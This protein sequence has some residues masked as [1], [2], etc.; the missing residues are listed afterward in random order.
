MRGKSLW[1]ACLT[2]VAAQWGCAKSGPCSGGGSEVDTRPLPADWAAA[3]PIP[4]GAVACHSA[5]GS[6]DSEYDRRY[7]LGSSPQEGFETW[8]THLT[9]L[10]WAAGADTSS[11]RGH[12]QVFTREGATLK[13][14]VS[15][16]ENVQHK[17]WSTLTFQPG[18]K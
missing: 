8:R 3:A 2:I 15:R 13:V 16:A 5:D 18:P 9:G 17:G 1:I 6:T 7:E 11:E 12:E 10:G 14:Y 4:T